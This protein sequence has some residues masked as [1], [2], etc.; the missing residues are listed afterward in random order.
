V[1]RKTIAARPLRSAASA[2]RPA[3]SSGTQKKRADATFV[4]P[5]R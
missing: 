4:A 3:P 2:A 5:A 1:P